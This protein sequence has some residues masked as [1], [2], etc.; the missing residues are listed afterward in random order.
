MYQAMI[1]QATAACQGMQVGTACVIQTQRGALPGTCQEQNSTFMCVSQQMGH[2]AGNYSGGYAG[3]G[4][5]AN[6]S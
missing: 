6:G 5:A 4:A 2:Y 1:Q 3:A